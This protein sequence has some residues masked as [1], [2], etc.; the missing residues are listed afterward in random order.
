MLARAPCRA[1]KAAPRPRPYSPARSRPCPSQSSPDLALNTPRH[2][3]PS[4][5]SL[6]H[7]GHSLQ[8]LPGYASCSV[9]FARGPWSSPSPRT[10]QSLAGD[11]ES[12]SPDSFR[13]PANVVRVSL[14]AILKFHPQTVSHLVEPPELTNWNIAP[15]AGRNPRRRWVRPP[16]HV[17]RPTPTIAGDDPHIGVTVKTSPTPSTTSPE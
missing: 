10:R 2:R 1:Y 3:P 6:G 5:P 7:C 9:N 4:P 13:S 17:D 8:P 16:A 11:P 15:W 14:C 12:P